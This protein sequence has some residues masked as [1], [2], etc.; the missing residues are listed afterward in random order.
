MTTNR[1]IIT[2]AFRLIGQ[3]AAGEVPTSDE[4]SDAL[5]TFQSI[6]FALPG[7]GF[8]D[9]LTE[10][11]ITA[12]Y[13]A[14]EDERI[15]STSGSPVV[16]LPT[17][18]TDSDGTVRPPRNGARVQIIG[19]AGKFYLYVSAQG[20]W[21]ALDDMALETVFP[22][23]YEH[24]EGFASVLATRLAPEYGAVISEPLAI[25]AER[26]N[27]LLRRAYNRAVATRS[28][29]AVLYLSR[30]AYGAYSTGSIV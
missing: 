2:R 27:R 22:L 7:I 5:V 10:V 21:V 8:P 24:E 29:D 20:A 3:L 23:G 30:Q 18:I 19:S 11:D 13:T 26:G 17:T 4:A 6:I 25:M 28:D 16:T 1:D 15:R 9:G 14:G 12:D